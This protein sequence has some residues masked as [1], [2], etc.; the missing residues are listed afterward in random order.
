MPT[1]GFRR[2]TI[3]TA[4][5]LWPAAVVAISGSLA[6]HL[7]WIA[8]IGKLHRIEQIATN[9]GDIPDF[10]SFGRTAFHPPSDF[11]NRKS[12]FTIR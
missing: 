4:S 12:R 3:P 6:L 2:T 9:Q 1:L 10:E 8:A 5:R 7:H 11:S